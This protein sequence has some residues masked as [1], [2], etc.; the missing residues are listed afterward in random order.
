MVGEN[1]SIDLLYLLVLLVAN[2]IRCCDMLPLS[3][4]RQLCYSSY[5]HPGIR[6][7]RGKIAYWK[8]L[9]KLHGTADS[10]I[11]QALYSY[12]RLNDT[13]IQQQI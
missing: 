13:E 10:C 7:A 11:V 1:A 5:H 6:V 2:N 3:Q 12:D 9:C 4:L 8:R